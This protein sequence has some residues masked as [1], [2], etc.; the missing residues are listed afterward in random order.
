MYGRTSIIYWDNFLK[1]MEFIGGASEKWNRE[2]II[3]TREEG[4]GKKI[5]RN[6]EELRE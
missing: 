1:G 4:R 6:R 3:I 5:K 2:D